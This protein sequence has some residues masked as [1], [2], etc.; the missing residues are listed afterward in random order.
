MTFFIG[1][2]VTT[3]VILLTVIILEE[4]SI[5]KRIVNSIKNKV[6]HTGP[7]DGSRILDREGMYI[8]HSSCY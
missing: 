5:F 8:F 2:M 3:D 4:Q 7:D 6:D 1:S